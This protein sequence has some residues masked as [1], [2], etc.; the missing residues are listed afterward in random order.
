MDIYCIGEI[1]ADFLPGEEE[2]VYIRNFGGAVA[3]VAV[4]CARC[5]LMAGI[6]CKVG[7]DDHGCFLEKTLEKENVKILSSQRC[8]DAVTT[9]AFV[10]LDETGERSFTFARKPGA[11]MFLSPDEVKEEDIRNSVIVHAGSC[12]LSAK[13]SAEATKKAILLGHKYG[14]IVSFDVN[15]RGNMWNGEKEKC[16]RAVEE[17]LPFCDLLKVSEEESD[18]LCGKESLP[19]LLKKYSLTTIVHTLG[20]MGAKV[21]YSKGILKE[22]GYNVIAADTTGAGDAFWGAFLSSL[23]IQNAGQRK[24]ITEDVLKKALKYGNISGAL[25]VQKK[26]AI[27][28]LPTKDQIEKVLAGKLRSM[29][30]FR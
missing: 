30:A 29:S 24:N 22:K 2:N 17:I 9:M 14:K 6:L 21:Y 7:D 27:T 11:D 12:S 13:M 4:A 15:Y 3:N 10:S 18:M 20:S 25:S 26:G 5:G 8:T 16:I 1:V 28:S 19:D 23:I